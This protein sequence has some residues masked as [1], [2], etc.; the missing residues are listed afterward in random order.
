ML[1]S[2][3]LL[4]PGGLTLNVF[5]AAF[6]SAKPHLGPP[7][8]KCWFYSRAS[9]GA[10][11][12]APAVII[13]FYRQFGPDL[14]RCRPRGFYEA[15]KKCSSWSC[16]GSSAVTLS[17]LATISAR[18]WSSFSATSWSEAAD[19]EKKKINYSP[20]KQLIHH[21]SLQL[22]GQN[23]RSRSITKYTGQDKIFYS[24]SLQE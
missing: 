14:Q 18:S 10:S 4:Q 1:F 3:A 21:R 22:F 17:Y 6:P 12:E 5:R 9:G 7:P 16:R 8:L 23:F 15:G 24:I 13:V 2:M 11:C 20:E 19:K